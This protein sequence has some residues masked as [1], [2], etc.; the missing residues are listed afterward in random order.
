MSGLIKGKEVHF[1]DTYLHVK[2]DDGRI[3]STPMD[4]YKPLKKAT[5]EQLKSYKLICLDTGIEWE[6][7]D[8]HL[9]IESMLNLSQSN[10]A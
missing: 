2:L 1:D 7:L 3:I 6:E 9:N 5:L 8:Y 4:W 10:A